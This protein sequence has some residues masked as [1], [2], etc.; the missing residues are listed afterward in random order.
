MSEEKGEALNA[1]KTS[2]ALSRDRHVSAAVGL[3][4]ARKIRDDHS[5]STSSWPSARSLAQERAGEPG[6]LLDKSE[7]ALDVLQHREEQVPG[8]A[9]DVAVRHGG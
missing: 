3:Y 1:A 5:S 7:P 4:L 8:E 6:V 9:S 2:A